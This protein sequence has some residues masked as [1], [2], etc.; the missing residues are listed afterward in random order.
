MQLRQISEHAANLARL[1]RAVEAHEAHM[2]LPMLSPR[3]RFA[4]IVSPYCCSE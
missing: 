2:P 4:I 3:R 1:P